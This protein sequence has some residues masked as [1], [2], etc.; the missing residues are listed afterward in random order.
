MFLPQF[1]RELMESNG[2]AWPD[3]FKISYL[4]KALNAK[5]IGYFIT[6]NPDRQNYPDFIRVI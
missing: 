2:A 3:Y 5:I 1:K 6:I 4:K